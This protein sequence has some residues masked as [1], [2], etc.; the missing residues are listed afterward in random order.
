MR[1]NEILLPTDFSPLFQ[2]AGQIARSQLHPGRSARKEN[3][4]L[5]GDLM[6]TAANLITVPLQTPILE[7]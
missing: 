7:A 6:T 1:L 2:L 4:M 5:V 3:V